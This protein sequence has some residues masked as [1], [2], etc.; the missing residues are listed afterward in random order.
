MGANRRNA[1]MDP[2]TGIVSDMGGAQ[3]GKSDYLK[4]EW[5]CV[6]GMSIIMTIVGFVWVYTCTFIYNSTLSDPKDF[7]P[8]WRFFCAPGAESDEEITAVGLD[9]GHLFTSYSP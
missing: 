9:F 3:G 1:K 6:A 4:S 7:P 2:T 8:F 5:C